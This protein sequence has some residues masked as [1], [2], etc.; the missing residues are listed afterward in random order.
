MLRRI[1]H[2]A[3]WAQLRGARAESVTHYELSF[4]SQ[5]PDPRES[6][7][8][9]ACVV[10]TLAM[11]MTSLL[12]LYI[13]RMLRATSL[14]TIDDN[15]DDD[16]WWRMITIRTTITVTMTMQVAVALRNNLEGAVLG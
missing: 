11:I 9:T 4:R 10:G 15:A 3:I 1:V 6:H 7:A 16:W 5:L 14:R 2:R 13:E 8:R 12:G